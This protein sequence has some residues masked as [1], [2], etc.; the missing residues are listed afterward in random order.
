MYS[1]GGGRVTEAVGH[2]GWGIDCPRS[3]PLTLGRALQAV[4]V[5]GKQW[6]KVAEA[7]PTRNAQQVRERWMNMLD[8]EIARDKPWSAKEDATL[9]KALHQCQNEN[10]SFRSSPSTANS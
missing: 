7:M 2:G 8:P 5:F 9:V 10:G 1:A 6:A 4:G 3:I